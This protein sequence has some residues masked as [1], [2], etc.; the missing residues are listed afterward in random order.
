MADDDCPK[1]KCKAGSPAWMCTFADLMSLLLCFFVLLLSFSVMDAQKYKMVKGSMKNAFGVQKTVK[2]VDSPSSDKIIS[3]EL[4]SI[5]IAVKI[6]KR[7]EEEVSEEMASGLIEVEAAG[8]GAVLL[9]MKD[10]LAFDFGKATIR[11]QF[12]PIL[13]AI[14]KVISEIE[15]KVTVYGHT[16]NVPLRKGGLFSSNW[17]LSA[18]R[19]VAVV[20]YWEDKFKISNFRMTATGSADGQPLAGNDTSEGRAKN[21]RVEFKLELPQTALTFKGLKELLAE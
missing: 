15:A 5:P 13:D 17:G 8:E 18:A 3:Q 10:S 4:P 19:S 21:R 12:F 9:R 16:D 7:L 2:V 11:K 1:V 20:E 6:I 14:G